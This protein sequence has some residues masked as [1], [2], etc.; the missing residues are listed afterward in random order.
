M[1]SRDQPSDAALLRDQVFEL[2]EERDALVLDGE[3]KTSMIE[4]LKKENDAL[5]LEVQNV[6]VQRK[7]D[8]AQNDK[9]NF[10]LRKCEDITSER[11]AL[12]LE[13][14]RIS[15]EKNA[16]RDEARNLRD[17]FKDPEVLQEEL[18]A[19]R[20][21]RDHNKSER[22]AFELRARQ[23]A[24]K[25]SAMTKVMESL[26]LENDE[27]R[28]KFQDFGPMERE[29]NNIRQ[30]CEDITNERNSFVLRAH[31]TAKSRE[32][33]EF[34]RDALRV[35]MEDLRAK[36]KDSDEL[37][38]QLRN[39]KTLYEELKSERDLLKTKIQWK[40]GN[41]RGQ[42]KEIDTLMQENEDLRARCRN[43][44]V[45]QKELNDARQECDKLKK[46]RNGFILRAQQTKKDKDALKD[47]VENLRVKYKIAA[48]LGELLR[49]QADGS[50]KVASPTES[51]GRGP[52]PTGRDTQRDRPSFT[53]GPRPKVRDTEKDRDTTIRGTRPAGRE[54]T[55]L[56]GARPTGREG[57]FIRGPR[58]KV[59]DTE[60]DRDTTIRG[61]IPK[62]R[63]TEAKEKDQDPT[64]RGAIPKRRETEAKGKDQDTT[65]RGAIPKRRETE[66]KGKDQ[67]TTI[68]GA[69]PKRRETEAKGKDQDDTDV[70]KPS[71]AR[72][73]EGTSSI[74]RGLRDFFALYAKRKETE[75][76]KQIDEEKQT[77]EENK[78]DQ[79]D[80]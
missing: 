40:T 35:E 79:E 53:R 30:Q 61:A 74:A 66:A 6:R 69:I 12:L 51:L 2:T 63:E 47:V 17:Q 75:Q 58:P 27:T 28:A 25:C 70:Q 64:I 23:L 3:R 55:F 22:D 38:T 4:F 9:L 78:T 16:L 1:E 21:Q 7:E 52:R 41:R 48:P 20:V 42:G 37:E 80:T 44:P 73:S 29:L 36:I 65:I 49:S 15:G 26:Q 68:H 24:A 39:A 8:A 59:R 45:L 50:P 71:W 18:N 67:D 76:E 14:R 62:R 13:Y 32:A 54:G 43:M 60:R 57:T 31:R 77:D 33:I 56:R 46:E 5:K 10:L 11:D 34:E 19:L 72:R